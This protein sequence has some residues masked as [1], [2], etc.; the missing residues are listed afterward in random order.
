MSKAELYNTVRGYWSASIN[1]IKR[2]NV[3]YVFGVYNGLIVAV[4]KPDEWYY[5]YENVDAPPRVNDDEY[6]RL[7]NRIYFVCKNY[8]NLD[9]SGKFYLYKTISNLKANQAAQNPI[10]YLSPEILNKQR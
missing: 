3:E 10:T 7:K 6:E 5:T 2:R 9:E 1:S 8:E 4:Y